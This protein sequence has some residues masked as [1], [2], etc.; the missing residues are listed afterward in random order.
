MNQMKKTIDSIPP[1]TFAEKV[2]V[3]DGRTIYH[4]TFNTQE[5]T[6]ELN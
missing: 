3:L 1:G 4:H 2:W 5:E 6:N